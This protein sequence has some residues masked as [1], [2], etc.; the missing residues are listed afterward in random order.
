[1]DRVARRIGPGSIPSGRPGSSDQSGRCPARRCPAP[2]SRP[3]PC[4]LDRRTSPPPSAAPPCAPDPASPPT[5]RTVEL[6]GPVAREDA[7]A[8]EAAA[9]GAVVEPEREDAARVLVGSGRGEEVSALV[10]PPGRDDEGRA[11]VVAP[12]EPLGVFS[13]ARRASSDAIGAFGATDRRARAVGSPV[14]P[15]E[16]GTDRPSTRVTAP[17]NRRTTA[18]SGAAASPVARASLPT[19]RPPPSSLRERPPAAGATPA[20]TDLLPTTPCSLRE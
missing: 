17:T 12:A 10:V 1:M 15:V 7:A 8:D 5:G 13:D 16:P 20:S 11:L 4:A 19:D 14:V 2:G 9:E 3:T 18:G 6:P